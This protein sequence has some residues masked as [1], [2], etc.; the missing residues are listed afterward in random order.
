LSLN[1]F[2]QYN[3]AADIVASNVRFRYNMAEGN[4][5]W[6]VYTENLN[7]DRFRDSPALPVS[8]NRTLLLKYTHTFIR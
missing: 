1:A 7:T 6:V 4:D 5:L 8:R 2:V 3:T